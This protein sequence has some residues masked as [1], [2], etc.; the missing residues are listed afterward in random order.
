MVSGG[1]QG[2]WFFGLLVVIRGFACFLVF[3]LILRF[4]GFKGPDLGFC[5]VLAGFGRKQRSFSAWAFL[6]VGVL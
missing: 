5:V 2:Y 3:L 1:L 6:R 4:G